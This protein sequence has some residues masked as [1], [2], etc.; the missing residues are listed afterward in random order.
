M[1]KYLLE[2]HPETLL[3]GDSLEDGELRCQV[4]WEKFKGYQ[5]SH[6]VFDHHKDR[7]SRVL[8]ICL[9]GDKGRTL[10]KS[11]IACYSWE[12]VW[13]LPS[14]LRNTPDEHRLKKRTEEKYDTGRLGQCCSERPGW[15]EGEVA[16]KHCTIKRRRLSHGLEER[17]QNHNSLGYLAQTI[18]SVFV[19]S[20][21]I[22][23]S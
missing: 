20:F 19:E 22:F 8:P 9:H 17:V 12:S 3:G 7:L 23:E 21:F 2:K 15:T 10:K 18:Y 11:P 13:G 1:A 4:F 6:V 16:A 14:D 5:K